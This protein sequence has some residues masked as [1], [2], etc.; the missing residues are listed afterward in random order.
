MNCI[1]TGGSKGIGR[2]IAENFAQRGYNLCICS[3]SMED[4]IEAKDAL[5]KINSDISVFVKSVDVSK[6]AEV[7]AFAQFA[8][9]VFD[10]KIDVLLNNAGVFIAGEVHSEED[11]NLEL[12]M[13][14]NLYSAYHLTRAIVHS[15]IRLNN[16]Y[17]INISSIA[18]ITAYPNG[19]SYSISKF[20]MRGMSL[21][22]REEL[23]D[24][25]IKVTNVMPGATW[26]NSWAGVDLPKSRLMA[27]EDIAVA[28]GSI[29]DLSDAAVM[30]EIILRP[31]LGDL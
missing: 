3:R 16:G 20:A 28:V 2:A 23:K 26:S 8:L 1:I 24:K 5:E 13:T 22:L 7:D 18:G 29:L 30:E 9:E 31:Q 21:V 15:M 6:K 12:M 25:G 19:G 27:A 10:N 17:I 4:L 14:T 11:G